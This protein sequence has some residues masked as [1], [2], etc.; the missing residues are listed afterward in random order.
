MLTP[1]RCPGPAADVTAVVNYEFPTHDEMYVH[2]IG[3]TGR[4]GNHGESMTLLARSTD[5]EHAGVLID[6]LRVRGCKEG[7]GCAGWDAHRR[8]AVALA[9]VPQ[10]WLLEALRG[11]S[12]WSVGLSM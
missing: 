4:A 5:A 10:Q 8:Q 3:R 2:R 12:L 11:L 7:G 1:T 6:A 9:V